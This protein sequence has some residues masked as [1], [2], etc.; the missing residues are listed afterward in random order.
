[1]VLQNASEGARRPGHRR[2]SS[3]EWDAERRRR[4]LAPH[5][6]LERGMPAVVAEDLNAEEC[7]FCVEVDE[8]VEQTVVGREDPA[9]VSATPLGGGAATSTGQPLNWSTS[10][11]S[12][13]VSH[14]LSLKRTL[15]AFAVPHTVAWPSK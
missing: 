5:M 7:A 10:V 12:L 6:A 3:C 15:N 13:Y 2:S 4:R 8:V 11:T 9:V 14:V 1:M